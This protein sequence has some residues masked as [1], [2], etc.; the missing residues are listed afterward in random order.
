MAKVAVLPTSGPMLVAAER[1]DD[2]TPAPPLSKLHVLAVLGRRSLPA[3][4][5]ATVAP[6]ILFYVFLVTVGPVA[7][8]LAALAWSYGAV[9][10]RLVRDGRIPAILTLSVL[11]LTLRTV[12]GILS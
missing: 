7:A 10:R 4:L 9:V 8:M 12:I 6:A 11:S 3:L 2:R 5:E 1:S